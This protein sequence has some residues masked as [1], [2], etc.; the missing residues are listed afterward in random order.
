MVSTG[1]FSMDLNSAF[2]TNVCV[3]TFNKNIALFLSLTG[4]FFFRF[5][6]VG[7]GFALSKANLFPTE[8]AH[9]VARIV[10]VRRQTTGTVTLLLCLCHGLQSCS[11]NQFLIECRFAMPP[12]LPYYSCV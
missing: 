2:D 10:M 11:L 6:T 1:V 8:A 9:G 12:L 4:A 5:L 3:H 7:A